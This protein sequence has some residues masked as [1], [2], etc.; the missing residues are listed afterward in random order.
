MRNP[1]VHGKRC[2]CLQASAGESVVPTRAAARSTTHRSTSTSTSP[3]PSWPPLTAFL[4]PGSPRAPRHGPEG[5]GGDKRSVSACSA[6]LAELPPEALEGLPELPRRAGELDTAARMRHF[7]AQQAA[8][9]DLSP[10][11][12][13]AIGGCGG[14]ARAKSVA[15]AECCLLSLAVWRRFGTGRFVQ[16]MGWVPRTDYAAMSALSGNAVDAAV[17]VW[18]TGMHAVEG[19]TNAQRCARTA[20]L[21]AWR[22]AAT[23]EDVEALREAEH[24]RTLAMSSAEIRRAEMRLAEVRALRA[25]AAG[26]AIVRAAYDRL[27]NARHHPIWDLWRKREVVVYACLDTRGFGGI[28]E[29]LAQ[30]KGFGGPD[31]EGERAGHDLALDLKTMT[32]F[33]DDAEGVCLSGDFS[34]WLRQKAAERAKPAAASVSRC[35]SRGGRRRRPTRAFHLD[36]TGIA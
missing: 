17:A 13:R 5:G 33:A 26:E 3:R 21:Q 10:G 9:L 22:A 24:V 32:P 27:L 15:F 16:A 12:L 35:S 14:V 31:E 28:R 7:I 23:P 11:D 2:A 30:V 4:I 29:A 25:T 1:E 20:E 19:G 8:S 6:W 36:S 34:A 18:K